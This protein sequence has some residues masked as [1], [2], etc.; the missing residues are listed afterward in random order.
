MLQLKN[1]IS[2]N[3][4]RN[5]NSHNFRGSKDLISTDTIM[6]LEIDIKRKAELEKQIKEGGNEPFKDS[7]LNRADVNGC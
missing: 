2:K 7:I 1:L 6:Q 4:L 5:S 3:K